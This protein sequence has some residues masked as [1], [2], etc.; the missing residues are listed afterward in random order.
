MTQS[1]DTRAVCATDVGYCAADLPDTPQCGLNYHFGMLLGVD[2]FRSE[3]GF[4]VGRLRRHQR[5]LHGAG[6]VAGF[7]VEFDAAGYDLKVGPGYAVDALGRDLA[8]DVAQCVNL[9]LWWQK[10]QH[11]EAFNDITHPEDATV[12]LDLLACYATCLSQP[13]PAIAE[14]CA[15]DTADI[16]YA[17]LCETVRLGLARAGT[18]PPAA[19][20]YHLLRLWLGLEPP[21]KDGGGQLLPDD[22]WLKQGIADLLALPAD[23]QDAARALLA[24]EVWA[25]ALAAES[26][27][28]PDPAADPN[29]LCLPLARLEGVHFSQD[30]D[31]WHVA[32]AKLTLGLRPLLLSSGLLQTL[33]LDGVSGRETKGLDLTTLFSGS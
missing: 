19:G 24:R 7:P 16:A 30:A 3:Q 6:V 33:L 18:A 13:V 28:A 20:H 25:R 10:H 15:T 27:A 32:I 14:P 22:A 8:L 17:R 5:L 12:D 23:Q 4:H 11:D 2:D 31:G 29:G 21:A 9:A 26:P 1:N